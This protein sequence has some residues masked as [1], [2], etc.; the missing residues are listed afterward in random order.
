MSTTPSA[1]AP[2]RDATENREAILAAAKIVLNRDPKAP[3]EAI[4]A[5]SGLSRRSI[6]AHFANRD[7]LLRELVS[8][9]ALRVASALDTVTHPDPL[10]RL[11]LIASRL[12]HEVE[13][14]RVMAVLAVRGP[15]ASDTGT[16]LR[17]VR[18]SVREAISDGRADGSIRQ[19][20]PVD[21]LARLVEGAALG[22]LEEAARTPLPA[23][24]GHRLV[25]L[26]TLGAVGLGWREAGNF[27]D[28]RP[29][30]QWKDAD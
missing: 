27:I 18:S 25:I 14:V 26:M 17:S 11:A 6:Y 5:A 13:S 3:L 7:D 22:V 29:D 21:L 30:L 1:R 28:E 24:E 8:L 20:V 15:L 23:E 9:G 2:R 10:T 12:W 4:A 19:D 16:A